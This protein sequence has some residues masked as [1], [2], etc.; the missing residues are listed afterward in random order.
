MSIKKIIKRLQ[1]LFS[2]SRNNT[3]VLGTIKF[4]D[5]KKRF[6]F[7]IA[8]NHEYFFHA[9]ATN[10]SDF[11]ALNDGVAVK[12]KIVQGKKGLQADQVELV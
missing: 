11:K 7:I 9:A 8:G 6:G 3:T 2:G 1:Q 4:F 12:F 10:R 5:R